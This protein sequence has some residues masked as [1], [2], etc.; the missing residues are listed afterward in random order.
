MGLSV[1]EALAQ[2]GLLGS[3]I[4]LSHTTGSTEE[5]LHISR[6]QGLSSLQLQ[7]PSHKWLME[8]TLASE[9][10]YEHRLVLIAG[11]RSSYSEVR[12]VDFSCFRSFE[13]SCKRSSCH[14]NRPRS[15]TLPP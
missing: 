3:V 6:N 5:E 15:G 11:C 12:L 1:P 13:Q 8:R 9:R 4:I 2:Y 10:M 14:A 7:V